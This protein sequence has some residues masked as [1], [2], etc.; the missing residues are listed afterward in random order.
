[1]D[2]QLDGRVVIVCGG[3]RGLGYAAARTLVDEGARVVVAGRDA[4]SAASAAARLG[5]QA[6]GRSIDITAPEA[7]DALLH[8]AYDVYGRV[9]GLFV[10]QGGPDPAPASEI[11][12]EQ[13][14]AA[15]RLAGEGPI[16]MLRTICP[17]LPAG[18]AA[19][20]LTSSTAY[21]PVAGMAGSSLARP[22]VHGFL[23]QLATE[24]APRDVRVNALIPGRFATARL[25]QLS[26]LPDDGPLSSIPMGRFGDP[27]ELGRVAAFLLSPAASYVTGTAWTVDGGRR[28]SL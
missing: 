22:A 13:L 14:T 27:S 17:E 8:S 1:M 20:A 5:E 23:K 25:D 16:R 18:G 2:L 7:P 12:D 11:S 28:R 10:S 4:E 26:G 15:W 21:E 24:L 9:D 19:I 6:V 3:T